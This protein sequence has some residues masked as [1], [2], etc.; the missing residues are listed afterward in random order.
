MCIIVSN[1]L[2]S[3]SGCCPQDISTFQIAWEVLE[4][5]RIIL[6]RYMLAPLPLVVRTTLPAVNCAVAVQ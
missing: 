2:H 4:T 3:W 6:Q 5:A 1:Q